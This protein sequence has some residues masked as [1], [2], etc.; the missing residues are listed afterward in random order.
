MSLLLTHLKLGRPYHLRIDHPTLEPLARCLQS[1][2]LIEQR[3]CSPA[4]PAH[5]AWT[6]P[7]ATQWQLLLHDQPWHLN[8][9]SA[10][11]LYLQTDHL[12]D[13]LARQD[14]PQSVFL[15]AG[16]VL[17]PSGQALLICGPSGAGK[18]SLVSACLS[19]GW[20]WLSDELLCFPGPDWNLMQGLKRN[21]NLKARSFPHF[22]ETAAAPGTFEVALPDARHR[23]RF[24]NPD[25]LR[26]G[27]H[28]PSAPLPAL[29]F[30]AFTPSSPAPP[31]SRLSQAQAAQR[32]APE[33]LTRHPATFAWLAAASRHAPAFLLPYHLPQDAVPALAH[34][35]LHLAPSS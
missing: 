17:T 12:L 4:T 22:P 34:L 27:Q 15:H 30:P 14:S 5:L 35:A 1:S 13:H 23:I 16:A 3:P 7:P 21:F 6:G 11:Q 20:P 32:L 33:L 26:P 9:L 31:P 28:R 24:F 8:P 29:I 19:H 2:T 18:S 25:A 10:T